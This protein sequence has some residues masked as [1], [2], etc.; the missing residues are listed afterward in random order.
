MLNCSVNVTDTRS[1]AV[2]CIIS[3]DW[4]T[5]FLYM[6]LYII[7]NEFLMNKD[8]KYSST[9]LI[10]HS[11]CGTVYTS[12]SLRHALHVTLYTSRPTRHALYVTPYT[13]R[14][15]RH[16]LF[17]M[18]SRESLW[19]IVCVTACLRTSFTAFYWNEF[20]VVITFTASSV[21]NYVFDIYCDNTCI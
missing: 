16:G 13:S 10:R 4:L 8:R 18:V 9:F 15:I 20:I 11:I 1:P 6:L 2:L 5:E 7:C 21:I 17:E 19:T 12:R 14:S 3:N